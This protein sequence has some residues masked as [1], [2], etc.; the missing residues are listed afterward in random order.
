MLDNVGRVADVRAADLTDDGRQDLVVAVFGWRENG[1]VM[2]MENVT[3]E[4]GQ[5][6]FVQ[7]V[8]DPRPGSIDVR[9]VDLDEGRTS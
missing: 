4:D 1:Q 2:W 6:G 9:I 8:L 7:H 3:A 5:T